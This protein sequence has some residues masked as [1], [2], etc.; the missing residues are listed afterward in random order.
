MVSIDLFRDG[1][2]RLAGAVN[3]ITTDGPQG[4][5]GI[6]AT[7]VC[8]VTDQPPTLLTC[9]NRNSYA[10]ALFSGNGVL[11]VNVL[12]ADQQHIAQLF[13]DRNISMPERRARVSAQLLATGSPALDG[14]LVSFDC[15]I[16]QQQSLGSHD[17]LICEVQAVSAGDG[18]A[19]LTY[20]RRNYHPVGSTPQ[21]PAEAHS[22]NNARCA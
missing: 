11:C 22:Q 1:M 20:F 14:A 2:A 10:H 13:S 4:F 5:A 18:A 19:G 9:I 3:V 7:A 15:R 8:S 12:A 16:V 6:T 17:L 21:A